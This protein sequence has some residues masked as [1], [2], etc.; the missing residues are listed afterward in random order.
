MKI[1][2]SNKLKTNVSLYFQQYDFRIKRF[3]W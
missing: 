2:K 1:R 3:E